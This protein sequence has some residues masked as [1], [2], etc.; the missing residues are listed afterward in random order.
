M[1]LSRLFSA[2]SFKLARQISTLTRNGRKA[3]SLVQQV[4]PMPARTMVAKATTAPGDLSVRSAVLWLVLGACPITLAGFYVTKLLKDMIEDVE[5][6]HVIPGPK[7]V[8]SND[9]WYDMKQEVCYI[10]AN[11]DACRALVLYK[12][13]STYS[14]FM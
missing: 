7:T 5:A 12:H 6:G 4:K 9:E 13:V 14:M 8:I 2:R 10:L 3:P 11:L 1:V